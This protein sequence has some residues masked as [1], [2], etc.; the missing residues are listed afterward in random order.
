[1][2]KEYK[3]QCQTCRCNYVFDTKDWASFICDVCKTFIHNK[4]KKGE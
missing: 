4:D 1:M 2:N 3:T